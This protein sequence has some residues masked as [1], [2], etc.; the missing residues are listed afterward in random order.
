VT[1]TVM[2]KLMLVKPS[3]VSLLLKMNGELHIVQIMVIFIVNP[4]P[5]LNAQVLGTVKISITFPLNILVNMIPM[6]MDKSTL[7]TILMKPI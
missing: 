7:V 4:N 1:S 5:V 3:N 6:V 2:D